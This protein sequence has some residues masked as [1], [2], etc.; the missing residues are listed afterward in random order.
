MS[1]SLLHSP[2]AFIALA[3]V[4]LLSGCSV[5]G[6]YPDA[7]E[8]DA[9]KLRF[10]S[11]TTNSTLFVYDAQH[12]MGET[13]GILN[14]MFLVD[15]KRRVDMLV[16]PPPTAH[17]SWVAGDQAGARKGHYVDDQHQRQLL[18]LWQSVQSNAQGG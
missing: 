10:I 2:R 14:N 17:G 9:A 3:L 12:C 1:L 13:T 18:C 6:T 5:H 11:N 15:T 4:T 16:P 8:P 7:A